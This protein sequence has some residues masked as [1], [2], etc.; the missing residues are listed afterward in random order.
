MLL[1]LD[2]LFILYGYLLILHQFI[3]KLCDDL[4]LPS[5]HSL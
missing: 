3:W 2:L 5:Y 1:L 4:N